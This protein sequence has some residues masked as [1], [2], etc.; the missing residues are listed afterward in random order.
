MIVSTFSFAEPGAPP[1]NT[2][3]VALNSTHVY[4]TWDPPPSDQINGVIQGY[5][6]SVIEL[7]TGDMSQYTVGDTETTIGPL[8]PHYTYNF[9]IVAFTSVGEGPTTYVV[10]RMDEAGELLIHMYMYT[11]EQTGVRWITL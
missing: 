9:S 11:L 7:D 2:T 5:R 4:L 10:V 8:H 1:S 6:I 3:G